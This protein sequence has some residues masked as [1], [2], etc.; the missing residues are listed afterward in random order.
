MG[1][2]TASSYLFNIIITVVTPLLFETIRWGTYLMFGCFCI[3]I[4]WMIHR[5]YPETRVSDNFVQLKSIV[6]ALM[7]FFFQGRSLE[8]V[9][10]IFSG[11]LVDKQPGA[12]HP[13]TAAEALVRMQKIRYRDRRKTLARG[14]SRRSNDPWQAACMPG[15]IGRSTYVEARQPSGA[16]DGRV[17]PDQAE[18]AAKTVYEK[19]DAP[20]PN[21]EVVERPDYQSQTATMTE[22]QSPWRTNTYPMQYL[23]KTY[24]NL[25]V[26]HTDVNTT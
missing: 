20:T 1:I 25:Y 12:H 15:H 6:L 19:D 23:M 13:D 14:G 9:N 3:A 24:Y 4:A 11:A 21:N 8:E 26:C 17:T 18:K 2:T 7:I 5:F 10:L 16:E 22:R